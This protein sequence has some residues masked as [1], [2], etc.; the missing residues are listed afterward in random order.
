MG[1]SSRA[2]DFIPG[3]SPPR[4]PQWF[5]AL[6]G[7]LDEHPH[8][9]VGEIGLDR[10]MENPNLPDQEAVFLQQLE[11]AA[12]RNLAVSIHCLKAWGPLEN[13]LKNNPRPERGFL[14]HS[15][16]G[17]AEMIPV[18]AKLGA[19]FSFSGYFAHD[20]KSAQREVFKKVP[21][22]R[23]LLETDAPDMLPPR[24]LQTFPGEINDP[25]NIQGIYEYA[26]G[27]WNIPLPQLAARMEANFK[28][29]F[30]APSKASG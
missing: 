11:L 4:T 20:R 3:S 23:L 15:Y 21:L 7:F 22:D 29:L 16:G 5:D 24:E 28:S 19:Y 9:G 8:A 18:F 27:L 17:S 2:L 13:A 25:R 1:G 30:L 14:V 26:A 6:R 10:W 12:E